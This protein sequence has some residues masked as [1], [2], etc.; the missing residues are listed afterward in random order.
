M[1]KACLVAVALFAAALFPT[2]VLAEGVKEVFVLDP[3]ALEVKEG[4]KSEGLRHIHPYRV[5]GMENDKLVV[6]DYEVQGLVSK[7]NTVPAEKAYEHFTAALKKNPSDHKALRYRAAAALRG[8]KPR[9]AIEDLSRAIE[10]EKSDYLAHVSRGIAWEHLGDYDKA[11][12]DLKA[13]IKLNPK[14]GVAYNSL[15]WVF[16]TCPDEKHRDGKKAVETAKK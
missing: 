13:A 4:Q 6:K 11:I 16:A 15:A 3:T 5:V 2:A 1:S 9:Q 14:S 12:A 8:G 7:E 10:V